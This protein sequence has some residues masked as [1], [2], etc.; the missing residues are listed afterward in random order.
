MPRYCGA[1]WSVQRC[2]G[3]TAPELSGNYCCKSQKNPLDE[4][5][6]HKITGDA[7][8][9]S[10]VINMDF[11]RTNRAEDCLIGMSTSA[12]RVQCDHSGCSTRSPLRPTTQ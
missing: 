2:H 12:F 4:V 7:I 9:V 8:T 11:L 10:I 1:S 6:S 3:V 5:D